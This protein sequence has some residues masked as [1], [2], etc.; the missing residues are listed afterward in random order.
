M[1]QSAGFQQ[2]V[3]T[4]TDIPLMGMPLQ[5]D[6]STKD[7]RNV[8]VIHEVIK[9]PATQGTTLKTIKRPGL[10]NFSQPPAGAAVGRGLYYWPGSGKLYSVFGTKIYS[11]TTDLGVT[12]ATSTGKVWFTE[13]EPTSAARLLIA[14][15]GK[16]NYNITTGDTITQI[17]EGDDAQYPQD[18]LGCILFFDSYLVQG[19]A[20]G[21]VWNTE[22]DSATSW[23]STALVTGEQY[24]DG[25]VAIAKQK[26]QVLAFGNFSLEFFFDNANS[27]SPLQR[28][29]QNSLQIGMSHRHTMA[30]STDILMW[31]GEAPAHGD[32][33]RTVWK[34]DGLTK[35]KEVGTAVI[36]RFLAAEGTDISNCSA[37]IERIAGHLLYVINLNTAG[38]T[39]VYDIGE[40][41]WCE[42]E[43]AAGSAKFVG[44]HVTSQDG[45][46]YVQDFTNGRI[47][48]MS[49]STY[50]DSGTN[51]TVT[52]QTDNY[53]LGSPF[54]K[55]QEGL[56][57]TGDNTTGNLS[58]SES[59][60][61]YVTFNTARTIDM[62]KTRKF[63]GEGGS[64]FRRAYR[65]T[66]A[67]NYP[68]R[69]EKMTLKAKVGNA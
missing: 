9:N 19:Q 27:G 41:T 52:I 46:I 58:V 18:N 29:D 25:L 38:R 35:I 22:A 36:N 6:T 34:I 53:D 63:L 61:D 12:L 42:W 56:W 8:N 47:Y 30:Q 21:E 10:A 68:L 33:G 15:D 45:T 54:N 23:I 49:A 37:W 20:D 50:Q 44:A 40:G 4:T 24:G 69:L 64:F 65:L 13:T 28:I 55:F 59:D 66:Y 43:A 26:D 60:D 31:V 57:I 3:P 1:A 16:D 32:G 2:P 7:Q 67:D 5:R 62:S 51:F 11:N 14:S 48:T 39:F 17:D